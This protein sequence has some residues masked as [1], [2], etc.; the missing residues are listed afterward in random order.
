MSKISQREALRTTS[1]F[2]C[3]SDIEAY[4]ENLLNS[5][6][7]ELKHT[8]QG[9]GTIEG[10]KKYVRSE[11]KSIDNILILLGISIEKFKRVVSW[12]RL[13]KGYTFDSE[14]TPTSLRNKMINDDQLMDEFCELFISGYVS[15]KFSSIVPRFI[16][17]DFRI[18][19]EVMKRLTSDD[20]VR[21]LVKDKVTT[22]YNT[23]YSDLYTKTLLTKIE[24]IAH[25]HGI[26]FGKMRIP[27]YSPEEMA[28]S[29]TG[30]YIVVNY[31]FYMTTSSSQT[32]YYDLTIKP[33]YEK[34][35][36]MDNV[37]I[38]NILDGAGWIGRSSDYK[39][40]YA[41]C[42]YFLNLKTI[43]KLNDIIIEFFNI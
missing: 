11:K 14:W 42:N 36:E 19:D 16:L 12:I 4:Y 5:Q 29:Y 6:V 17:R 27:N 23:R 31:H 28:L 20:Y 7:I 26:E 30:K 21:N 35:R 13:S 33:K 34:A 10:L 32:D 43:E 24:G 8:L 2:L 15:E 18:D 25:K 39:K 9:I 37:V 1:M 3:D 40:I 41:D 22:E 38:L